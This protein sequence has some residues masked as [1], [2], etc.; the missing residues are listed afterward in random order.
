MS[1]DAQSFLDS[2]YSESN[3]TSI[4]PVPVGEYM[5]IIEKI[6]PRQWQSK[7]GTQTGIAI[8]I[9]WMIEDDSVKQLLGRDKVTC[10][11]SIMLDTTA[12]GTLD[13]SRGHNVG[14]GRL[15]EAVGKNSPGEAFAFSMLPGLSAKIHVTHRVNNEDIFAEVKMVSKL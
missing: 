5:G 8:D 12:Q 2:A 14:L 6:T 4:A 9:T 3:D 10:R 11:Q 7:D 15:R 13:M 1:F